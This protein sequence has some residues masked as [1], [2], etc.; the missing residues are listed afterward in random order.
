MVDMWEEA[1]GYGSTCLA[2]QA[3]YERR[4]QAAQWQLLSTPGPAQRM[5]PAPEAH[6]VLAA[7][8][9]GMAATLIEDSRLGRADV[10]GCE[11]DL[12]QYRKR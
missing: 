1:V 6:M 3:V 12:K 4:P 11:A 5:A 10:A 8:G 7:A 2:W 9:A